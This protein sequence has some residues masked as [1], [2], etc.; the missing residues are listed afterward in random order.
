MRKGCMLVTLV[1]AGLAGGRC[2]AAAAKDTTVDQNLRLARA[3]V[4]RSDRYMDYTELR[5]GMRG[6]GLTVMAGTGIEKFDATVISVVHNWYPHQAVILCRLAGLGLEKTGVISGMSGSPVF[7]KDPADGKHKLVGAVAYGW[8][9]QKEP[10]CGLQPIA[11]MLAVEGV[12]LPGRKPVKR[13]SA[14]WAGAGGLDEDLVRAVLNPRKVSFAEF[15]LPRRLRARRRTARGPRLVPLHTPVM[16]AGVGERTLALAERIFAG[17]GLVP[18][19]AGA[20]G[21]AEAA[22]AKTTIEPGGALS[23]PLVTGDADWAAVGTVTDVIGDYVLGFGHSFFAEGH[24]E[25]PMGPAYVHT[26]VPSAYTSFKLGSTLKIT[27]ALLDDEYTGVGGR[28]GHK[29]AMVP[30]TVTMRWDGA[31]QKFN[32][33]IVRHNW[34]TAALAST[35]M[36]ESL[37][38][39]RELPER[40][41]VE[42]SVDIEF[43]KH[44]RYHAENLT[45]ESGSGDVGSD[46]TRPLAAMAN[47][48]LG[49]PVFPKRIDVT[50]SIRRVQKTAEVLGMELERHEYKPGQTVK[51]KVTMRAFRRPRSTV[52]VALELPDDL[53]DGRYRLGVTDGYG[54]LR[55][56]RSEMP[57]R[58]RPRT[59]EQLF[60]AVQEVVGPRM[61]RLYVSLSLPHGGVAVNADELD[62]LPASWA[63]LL[64]RTAP[65]D[66]SRY[67]RSK[68]VEFKT[69]Y[70]MSGS[71]SASF[72]VR[73]EPPR[74]H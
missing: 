17:T 45:S 28:I 48:Y 11:Q 27:G 19:Q 60:A 62:H 61:D 40:H 49:R 10:I 58:F 32:Y 41:T 36:R 16:V 51:G 53:P 66:T 54:L 15:A 21:G 52:D 4:A 73:K 67:R 50:M 38:A 43:E 72:T 7:I 31:E 30:L 5:R 44:G 3:F 26:V 34:L 65:R 2:T 9:F 47:S 37:W 69:D 6:Y 8:S 42:Y 55:R 35:M 59:V 14:A 1:L 39:N 18:V 57:H 64:A 12:P 23:I 33:N 22:A 29:A 46:L 63:E 13:E 24:V 56:R 74:S 70:V 20:V 68:T 25:F 71:A